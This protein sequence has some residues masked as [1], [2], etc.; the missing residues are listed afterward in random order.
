[1]TTSKPIS[2]FRLSSLLRSQKDPLLAFKLFL[3]PNPNPNKPQNRPFRHSL[4]SYDLIIIKLGRAKMFPEMEQLLHKLHHET[5]FRVPEPLFCHVIS[6]Y[7]QARLPARAIRTF[8]SIPSFRCNPTLK[9]FNSL[10]NALLN[11]REFHLMTQLLST[12]HHFGTPDACTYNILINA[13]FSIGD[14]ERAYKVFDEMRK[15]GVRPNAVTFGTMIN[16]LCKNSRLHEAF[17][18]KEDMVKVFKLE[19]SVSIYTKLIKGV[20]EIGEFDWAFRIKEEM[21]MSKLRLDATL[22]N[23][24]VSALFKAR[25]KEEGLRVL[26]EMKNSGCKADSV[27]CNVMIGEFCREKNFEEAY[28]VLDGMEGLKQDVI[29]YNVIIGWLCKEGKWREAIDLFEDMPRRQCAPDVVTHRTL[30]DGLCDWMQFREAAFVLDEMVF[31]GYVPLS[32]SLNKFVDGLSREGNSELLSTVLSCLG[33]GNCFNEDLWKIV[34]S[35]VCKPEKLSEPFELLDAL[36][37][38]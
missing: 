10:L 12:V 19:P 37:L 38:G 33:R 26:E 6:F 36:V 21:V 13:W 32:G 14:V 35:M 7:G 20:C 22:Y 18:V 3:N 17:K 30:F 4:L 15:R 24:L 29:S 5:I 16:G 31:K 25:R 23:T 2:P 1:M 27:T 9:S 8:R 11:C 28:R 34:V